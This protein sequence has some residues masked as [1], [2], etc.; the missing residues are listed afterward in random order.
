M[1][2]VPNLSIIIYAIP[3]EIDGF[4]KLDACIRTIDKMVTKL[5]IL[6][7]NIYIRIAI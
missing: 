1:F 3:K 7:K 5:T 6:N 2:L 4:E